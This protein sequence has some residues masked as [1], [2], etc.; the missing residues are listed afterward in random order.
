MLKKFRDF[1]LHKL[2]GKNLNK[3]SS[4]RRFFYKTIKIFWIAIDKVFRHQLTLRA[5]ALTYFS[6]M[7]IVPFF[8]LIF[9]VAK[10][11]GDQEIIEAELLERFKEQQEI[12]LKVIEFAKNLI[13]EAKGGLIAFVGII[14]LFWSLIKLLSN[15]EGSL[16]EIWQVKTTRKVKRR[17]SNYLALMFVIPVFFVTFISL[18]IYISNLISKDVVIETIFRLPLSLAPYLLILALFTFIYVFMPSVKVKIKYALL[19]AVLSSAIYQ[20]VQAIYVNFQVGITRFNAIYGS[21]A[22]LPLF[23]IWLQISWLIF[24]FGAQFCFAI[25]NLDKIKIKD[26]SKKK[27]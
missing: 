15:L 26:L 20:I 7:A 27:T 6:L 24:L 5:S 21:F 11:I 23:L 18:R 25:Q 19:S 3:I 13:I 12:V 22:A 14:F 2:W 16:N 1:L 10:K 4:L 8:A 17:L 9:A